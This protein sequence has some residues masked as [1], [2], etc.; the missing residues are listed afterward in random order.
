M[1]VSQSKK[2]LTS[3]RKNLEYLID[4]DINSNLQSNKTTNN[5]R[6]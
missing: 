4:Q 1:M 3:N 5:Y 2:K 6:K